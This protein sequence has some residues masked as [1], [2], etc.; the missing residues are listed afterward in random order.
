MSSKGEN[1][2]KQQEQHQNI[3]IK[4]IEAENII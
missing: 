1:D 3:D 2:E 4:V